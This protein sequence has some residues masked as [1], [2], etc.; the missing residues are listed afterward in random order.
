MNVF[1]YI[2]VSDKSQLDGDGFDRQR[3]AINAFALTKG[4]RVIR[5]FEE[6]GVSGTVEHTD[7][8]AFSEMLDLCGPATATT[9]VVE[10]PD[11][12]ARDLIVSEVLLRG[13]RSAGLSIYDAS[14]NTDLSN[15]DDPSRVLIRQIFGALAEFEKSTLVKKLKAAKD[16]I[17]AETGRCEGPKPFETTPMGKAASQAI[18][19]L[20]ERGFTLGRIAKVLTQHSYKSPSG[21]TKWHK[22]TIANILSRT[23]G[24]F[25]G[26]RPDPSLLLPSGFINS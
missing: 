25:P 12:I 22:S 2:R 8:P 17:R 26:V 9:I 19:E 15:V 24:S 4:W 1:G 6:R 14:S 13:V 10:R 21:G 7:R 23:E 11:R 20:H 5:F 3:D 16:R 18:F